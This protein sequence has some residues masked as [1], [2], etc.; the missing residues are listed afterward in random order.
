MVPCS[1]PGSKRAGGQRAS[2]SKS[3]SKPA[4]SSFQDWLQAQSGEEGTAATGSQASGETYQ[5]GLEEEDDELYEQ[6]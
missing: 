6:V 3:A 2:S 1:A 5:E 4:G